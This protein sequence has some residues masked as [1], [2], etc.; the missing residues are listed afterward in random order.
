M[1]LSILY[2][3]VGLYAYNIILKCNISVICKICITAYV[4][5][6]YLKNLNDLFWI[7][8][9]PF[10]MYVLC[11]RYFLQWWP[12][13]ICETRLFKNKDSLHAMTALAFQNN[14]GQVQGLKVSDPLRSP[15]KTLRNHPWILDNE[16]LNLPAYRIFGDPLTRHHPHGK[17]VRHISG[18]TIY[19]LVLVNLLNFLNFI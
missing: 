3:H 4:I 16:K 7:F 12:D 15:E 18:T 9:Y 8:S 5:I 2:S 13:V 10:L 17:R 14:L 11:A 6:P 19:C 1:Y